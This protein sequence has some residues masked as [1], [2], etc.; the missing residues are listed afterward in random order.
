MDRN[1]WLAVAVL[2]L[3][4]LSEQIVSL[5]WG[6]PGWGPWVFVEQGGRWQS[7]GEQRGARGGRVAGTPRIKVGAS[8]PSTPPAQGS[9]RA[10]IVLHGAQPARQMLAGMALEPVLM[11]LVES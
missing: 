5:S 9:H 4:C 3:C 6:D 10:L 7:A 11:S 8:A 1:V 2:S